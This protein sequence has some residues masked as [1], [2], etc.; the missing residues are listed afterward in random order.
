MVNTLQ[1]FPWI[2]PRFFLEKII[3]DTLQTKKSD[4]YI[5]VEKEL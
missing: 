1:N 2:S 5:G 3:V 4:L